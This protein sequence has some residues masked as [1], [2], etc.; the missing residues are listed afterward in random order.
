MTD[1]EALGAADGTNGTD[2]TYGQ[3]AAFTLACNVLREMS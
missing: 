2:E 1:R 3:G